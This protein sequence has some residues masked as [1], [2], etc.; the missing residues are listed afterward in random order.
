MEK[1]EKLQAIQ[2]F[3]DNAQIIIPTEVKN[4]LDDVF[5]END[6]NDIQGID[7]YTKFDIDEL[8]KDTFIDN[9]VN[10][11]LT[12]GSRGRITN[13]FTY[14]GADVNFAIKEIYMLT[15]GKDD[16]PMESLQEFNNGLLELQFDKE[17]WLVLLLE[18]IEFGNGELNKKLE[19]KVYVPKE[20]EDGK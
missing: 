1:N 7:I 14:Y 13:T 12:E 18:H 19:L 5:E 15:A 16:L 11:N 8:L 3:F 9:W 20:I 10:I 17:S 2:N 4:S 6:E